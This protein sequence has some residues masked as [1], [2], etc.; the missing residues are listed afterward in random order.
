MRIALCLLV[1]AGPLLAEEPPKPLHF[2]IR[3]TVP[4]VRELASLNLY[5]PQ[6]H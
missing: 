4:A 1:L 5:S 6:P 3:N 2:S